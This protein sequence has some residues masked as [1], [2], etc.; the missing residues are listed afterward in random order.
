LYSPEL[1]AFGGV[2]SSASRQLARCR[3]PWRLGENVARAALTPGDAGSYSLALPKRVFGI[4]PGTAFTAL[5]PREG[6]WALVGPE[7]EVGRSVRVVDAET[8]ELIIT[9]SYRS[10]AMFG[11]EP[12][13][14]SLAALADALYGVKKV[15]DA[16][17]RGAAHNGR[18]QT[19]YQA[20]VSANPGAATPDGKRVNWIKWTQKEAGQRFVR[21]PVADVCGILDRALELTAPDVAASQAAVLTGLPGELLGPS[22]YNLNATV[23]VSVQTAAH[24]DRGNRPGTLSSILVLHKGQVRGGELVLPDYGLALEAPS[25]TVFTCDFHVHQHMNLPIE[26][27]GLAARLAL[28]S[29]I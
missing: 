2:R 27:G 1:W 15:G 23:N 8:G 9:V 5:P 22:R 28:A 16:I 20:C 19:S 14:A 4:A 3:R 18:M 17:R 29:I 26:A 24:T 7:G 13:D 10:P 25:G 11:A 21:G 12:T 6:G